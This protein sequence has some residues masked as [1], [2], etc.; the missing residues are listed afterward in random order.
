MSEGITWVA[1]DTSKKKHVGVVLEPGTRTPREF[2]IP[3]ERRAIRRLGRKLVR[4]APGE[5]RVCYEAGPCGYALQRQ[6]EASAGLVCEVIAPALIPVRPGE[7]IKT[8]RR[9]AVKLVGLYRAGEL[10]VVHPPSEGAEAVRDLMRCREDAKEDLLRARHRLSKLL[11]RRGRIYTAGKQ[12]TQRHQQWMAS[13]VWEEAADGVVF[14]EYRLGISQ[15]EDRLHELDA[16]VEESSVRDP[17]RE[18]VGWLR[19][20]RGIDTVT[21]MTIVAEVHEI[22]RFQDAP[23]FMGYLGVVPSEHSSGERTSRG[24]ITKAGN[25]HVRRILVESAWHSRHRPAVGYNLRKR[26]EGQPAWV[27]AHAD[28]AMRRLSRRYRALQ[29]RGKLHNKIAVAVARELAGFVW[30]VLQEGHQRQH[31]GAKRSD[32]VAA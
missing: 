27:I 8:D 11:L 1:L 26:R 14:E 13:Q 2:S 20:F 7:R 3:N 32:R 4:E 19:C 22:T 18:P 12:W 21:A 15:L 29:A 10:T 24:G 31:E 9:D 17:Y 30:A 16:R 23:S 25:S 6:L 5:V 28:R